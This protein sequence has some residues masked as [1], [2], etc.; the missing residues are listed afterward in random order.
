MAQGNDPGQGLESRGGVQDPNQNIS[1]SGIQPSSIPNERITRPSAPDFSGVGSGLRDLSSLLS[2][3]SGLMDQYLNQQK[4]KWRVQGQL[5][6]AQGK[7]QNDLATQGNQY[8]TQGYQALQM[9]DTLQQWKTSQLL[10][11]DQ[12]NQKLEPDQYRQNLQEGFNKLTDNITD[13][14]IKAHVAAIAGRDLPEMLSHQMT[15]HSK[16]NE[17]QTVQS[18]TSLLTSAADAVNS[19][20]TDE[21]KATAQ[22]QLSA[23]VAHA[24]ATLSDDNYQKAITTATELGLQTQNNSL[25]KTMQGTHNIQSPTVTPNQ[26]IDY[27]ID[28][29]E[30]SSSV[31]H[32]EN[33]AWVKFGIDQS[34]NPGVDVPNLTRAQAIDI[35][36]SK[37]WDKAGISNLDPKM[38]MPA[39]A[40]VINSGTTGGT[41]MIAASGGDP[42][43]LRKLQM[44]HFENLHA[45]DP[46]KYPS[47]DGWVN[48]L[49]KV[50][51]F[52]LSSLK[53]TASPNDLASS[54]LAQGFSGTNTQRLLT[55]SLK[56]NSDSVD[57]FDKQKILD[58]DSI[59]A[60][61]KQKGNESDAIDAVTNLKMARGYDDRWE[62]QM[63]NHVRQGVADHDTEQDHANTLQSA[64]SN[65]DMASLSKSD[66]Q[67]ALPL[68]R[69][70]DQAQVKQAYSSGAFNA[71]AKQRNISP[72]QISAERLQGMY[73]QRLVNNKV[74]DP[75]IAEQMQ[76]DV[77]Q[78]RQAKTSD[79][80]DPQSGNLTPQGQRLTNTVGQYFALQNMPGSNT[81]FA[82]K[83]LSSD[84]KTDVFMNEVLANESTGTNLIPSVMLANSYL[85][86]P[87]G[88]QR[89][90]LPEEAIQK[91]VS[92]YTDR[93]LKPGIMN[94]VFG[95]EAHAGPGSVTDKEVQAWKNDP[96]FNAI[97]NTVAN[98]YYK[99]YPESSPGGAIAEAMSQV[100]SQGEFVGGSF[101][102]T[103]KGQPTVKNMMGLDNYSDPFMSHQAVMEAMKQY[104]ST[105]AMW[106]DKYNS[107][108]LVGRPDSD[109]FN[110]DKNFL[111]SLGNIPSLSPSAI[112]Q[113]IADVT[114]GTPQA[115]YRVDPE[116]KSL[117][118]TPFRNKEGTLMLNQPRSIPLQFIGDTWKQNHP[119]PSTINTWMQSATK[120]I[121]TG[122]TK[123]EN[124][125]MDNTNIGK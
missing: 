46:V 62:G 1:N 63:M 119:A 43:K 37:Y 67:E 81:E 89:H 19:A 60:I 70:M 56:Y 16:Y 47:L 79:L 15:L 21:L 25:L 41:N 69:A 29:I 125:L 50:D 118:I 95:G 122:V 112:G 55:A 11:M 14:Y 44:Q 58:E 54:L 76:S 42:A 83:F 34:K 82:K 35:Y 32:K 98:Q 23:Y 51:N 10:T 9:T 49:D 39:F 59:R 6:Y 99:N 80:Q 17:D 91:G 78:L 96:R 48:R 86:Q 8:T 38:Q 52:Q 5:M 73:L 22:N 65:N 61:A 88:M 40:A 116:T 53:N 31:A 110:D 66:L 77:M 7:T 102:F 71:E 111:Q 121:G 18:N 115:T 64:I 3:G 120:M 28:K 107:F 30:G 117:I 113:S 93:N 105:P 108:Q 97:V 75:V 13:P 45:S 12:G 90:N 4:D 72:E 26:I 74:V 114:R 57:S 24:K 100:R 123:T 92:D 36:K 84:N 85:N 104:G 87:E 27:T 106:G 20:P 124:F 101:L 94:M 2:T 109:S 33:G 103:G 68:A